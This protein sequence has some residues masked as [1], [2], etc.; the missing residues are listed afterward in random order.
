MLKHLLDIL[1]PKHCYQCYQEG[2]YLCFPNQTKIIA[3]YYKSNQANIDAI[4][5]AGDYQNEA[6][7]EAIHHMKYNSVKGV[8]EEL[9]RHLFQK[10]SYLVKPGDILVPVPLSTNRQRVRGFNQAQVMALAFPDNQIVEALQRIKFVKRQIGL[11]RQERIENVK[12][13]FASGKDVALVKGKKVFLID[14]VAT[15][16]ATLNACAKILKKAGA[17]QVVGLVV[18][19]D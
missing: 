16:G 15:T 19:R 5:A 8:A 14:D 11:T 17:K 9:G 4:L 18:A 7:K 13:A 10:F 2:H 1:F 6:L 12:N 3:N